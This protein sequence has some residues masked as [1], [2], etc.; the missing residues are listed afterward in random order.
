MFYNFQRPGPS[1]KR[2]GHHAAD[3]AKKSQVALEIEI[4]EPW[5]PSVPAEQ[6]CPSQGARYTNSV[7]MDTAASVAI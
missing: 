5:V 7:I 3:I 2:S 4:I 6:S 1:H